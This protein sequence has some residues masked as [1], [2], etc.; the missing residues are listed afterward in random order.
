ML[1]PAPKVPFSNDSGAVACFLERF[2]PL[3][4]GRDLK[5]AASV[6]NIAFEVTTVF[7]H[8][9]TGKRRQ[10]GKMPVSATS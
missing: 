2:Y 5:I 10:T 8:P 4:A 9:P 3:Q 6:V 7:T 1:M